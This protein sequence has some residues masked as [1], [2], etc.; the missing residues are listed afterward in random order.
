METST[1]NH[2][3]HPDQKQPVQPGKYTVIINSHAYE[4]DFIT[5]LELAIK[6]DAW[7]LEPSTLNTVGH[8]SALSDYD[9]MSIL[10]QAKGGTW[11]D[12]WQPYCGTC[13]TVARMQTQPYGFQCS[14]CGNMIGFNL[15]RLKESPLN[16][17][18]Q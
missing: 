16:L 1:I 7:Y 11:Y 9:K 17:L 18:N 3:H 10:R 5:A 15:V 2:Q 14:Y 12:G 8:Q 4:F 6:Y 13:S